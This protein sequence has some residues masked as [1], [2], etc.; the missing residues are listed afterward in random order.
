MVIKLLTL[1]KKNFKLIIRSKSSALIV[2]FGPLLL[3]LLISAAFNT[4]NIYGIRV[5][6]FSEG[7]NELVD[8]ILNELQTKKF[9]SIKADNKDEC[10]DGIKTGVFHLCAYFTKDFDIDS[11]E[12]IFYVDPSEVNLVYIVIDA[13]S[14]SIKSKTKEIGEEL[15]ENVI[16]SLDKTK[17]DI[18][19]KKGKI[20]TIIRDSQETQGSLRSA[21]SDLENIDLDFDI[22]DFSIVELEGKLGMQTN[23]STEISTLV[24]QLKREL[25]DFI[26]EANNADTVKDKASNKINKAENQVSESASELALLD[27]SLDKVLS[28]ID[29]IKKGDVQKIV[30]PI[31]TRIEHISSNKTFLNYLFP[32]LIAM[33]IMFVGI[34]LSSTLEIRE[35]SAKIYFKNF[36]TPTSNSLF[37]LS[38]YVTNMVIIFL[39]L[40]ILFI[41]LLII[42]KEQLITIIGSLF[43]I[44]F[45]VTSVFIFL[46]MIIGNIFKSEETN[47]IAAIS[48]GFILLFFSSAI[49]PIETLPGFIKNIANYNPFYISENILSKIMLFHTNLSSIL[50]SIYLLT[51]ILIGLI[52]LTY[53]VRKFISRY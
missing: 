1:V 53:A 38:N 23:T 7:E 22:N 2:I 18:S 47:T 10:L 11:G 5:G 48:I 8:S 49:L 3:I 40:F 14:S 25:E 4:A 32:T 41:V 24:I 9:S 19:D 37:I 43:I 34:L 46:G 42:T 30:T 50:N 35:K 29:L 15:V 16:L 52:V 28:S 26:N 21:F 36:I 6:Y 20:T 51:G 44:L 31:N 12:L 33:I 27:S 13:V 45:L 17:R 39:Q